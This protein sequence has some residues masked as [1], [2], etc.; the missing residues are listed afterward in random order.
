MH[1]IFQPLGLGAALAAMVLSPP[2]AASMTYYIDEG[3]S[4]SSPVSPCVSNKDL[5]TVTQ[6]LESA[7][8]ADP[9]GAFT[10]HR[11]INGAAWS[12]DFMESCSSSF[13]T[14][15]QDYLYADSQ[16]VAVFAGH[17]AAGFFQFPSPQAGSCSLDF[18]NNARLG[19]MNGGQAVVGIWLACDTLDISTLPNEANWEWLQQ[20]FGF[21]NTIYINDNEPRDFFNATL[22]SSNANAW[23]NEFNNNGRKPAAISY[24]NTGTRCWDVNDHADMGLGGYLGAGGGWST[25][26]GG[27]PAFSY[28]GHYIP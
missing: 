5:N 15:G 21:N 11:Y 17:G 1:R 9:Y 8:K 14:S 25:C 19:A 22:S 27:E 24:G 18:K 12:T 6:T 20:Q 13:G 28:C 23:I 16:S 7:M 3:T 10:G 26:G 2:A 4:Y